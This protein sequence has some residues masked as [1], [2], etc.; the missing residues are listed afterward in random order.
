MLP[1]IRLSLFYLAGYLIPSGLAFLAFP[2]LTLKLLFSNGSYGDVFPRLVGAILI[3]QIIRYRLY[4]LYPTAIATQLL[5]LA[6][7]I[8]LYAYQRDPAFL[9][10]FGVVG[11]GVALTSICYLLDRSDQAGMTVRSGV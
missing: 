9:V 5:L 8:G 4:Q 3:A 7:L 10:L 1:R 11:F 6:T 2:Q